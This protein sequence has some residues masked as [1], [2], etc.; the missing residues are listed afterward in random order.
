MPVLVVAKAPNSG[1]SKTR[2]VPPLTADQA[3]ALHEALLLDTVD[4]CRE[5]DSDVR[6]L[7]ASERDAKVLAELVPGVRRVVQAGEGLGD[8]LR[9][10]IARHTARGATAIVSSDIPGLPDGAIPGAFAALAEGADVVLGPAEDGGYWLVA[11]TEA[12]DE[13][14]RH[15]PWSTPAV[16][17]VTRERCA[18][19]GLRLVELEPWRDVDTPVDL[20]L[21][22][23][24]RSRLR[25]PRTVAV[26]SAL[27]EHL[28]EAPD[29]SLSGSELLSGSPWRAVIRDRLR[30]DGR[31]TAYEYLAVPRAV[32]VA[33][34][35]DE[36][37]L[38]L[39]RQYRHPVR[40]WTLEV[41]AGSVRE[42]ESA[43][44]AAARELREETGGEAREWHHLTTFYSSSAHT[45]LR[46]DAWLALG[47]EIVGAP[48]EEEWE[49]VT[50]VRMPLEEALSRARAGGFT[51]GQTALTILLAAERL[52]QMSREMS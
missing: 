4:A 2:L 20:E 46:S 52:E 10:G 47:V 12:H 24:D 33:A 17:A 16:L 49:D 14:F 30:V 42:G 1:R 7:C 36:G 18:R 39:V 5:Q 6:L 9:L 25:A 22:A 40:D 34:V 21:L 11:M 45:S 48:I 35:S 26:L 23:R 51:E 32:F 13:P 19:A 38:L 44:D 27:A 28:S 8:A 50:V 37:E 29:V 41:P 3:A 43:Y 31:E 15:I